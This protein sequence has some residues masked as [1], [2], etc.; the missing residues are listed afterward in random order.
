MTLTNAVTCRWCS[1]AANTIDD[2][3]AAATAVPGVALLLAARGGIGA[4][5]GRAWIQR[6]L[7]GEARPATTPASSP[8]HVRI[9][10]GE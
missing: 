4:F 5:I 6:V 1:V 2:Q 7:S 3:A 9:E 8:F 10:S